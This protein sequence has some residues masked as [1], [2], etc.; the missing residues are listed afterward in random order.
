MEIK[1]RHVCLDRG[2]VMG[3]EEELTEDEGGRTVVMGTERG[4]M[5]SGS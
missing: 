3:E 4:K 2:W 5:S 1:E